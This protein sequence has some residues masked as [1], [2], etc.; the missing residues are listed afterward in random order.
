[1][2]IVKRNPESEGIARKD[3]NLAF[4]DF[5]SRFFDDDIFSTDL[6]K[7][8]WNPRVDIYEK[9]NSIVVKADLPG[10][11]EKN[12][13]VVLEDHSLTI[14]GSREEE[15]ERKDKNFHQIERSWGSF[16]R[17][18][19]LPD[20]VKADKIQAEYKSGVL[21]V[22]LPKEKETTAKKIQIKAS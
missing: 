12:L 15:T 16:S 11:D 17:S 10:I 19:T 13:N 14:S 1:M 18:I 21:T 5:F 9:G 2:K 8:G 7:T 22:T 20:D 6:A 4:N 3:L